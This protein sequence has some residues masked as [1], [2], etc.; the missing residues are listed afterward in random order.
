MCIAAPGRIVE[1]DPAHPSA[2]RVDVGGVRRNVNL[3]MLD[4]PSIAV[5]DWVALHMGFA[6]ERLTEA[7]ALEALAFAENDPFGMLL[8]EFDG[9]RGAPA[10]GDIRT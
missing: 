10:S 9:E 3:A 5:G 1:I 2:A 7:Q 8:A 4:D 6:I